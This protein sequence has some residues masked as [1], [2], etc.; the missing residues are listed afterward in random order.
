MQTKTVLGDFKGNPTISI[1]EI[2]EGGEAKPMPVI[3]FGL[4]KAKAILVSIEDIK[5]FVEEKG[6]KND[7]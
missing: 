4:K 3:S 5:K 1:F 7:I 6:G 2:G